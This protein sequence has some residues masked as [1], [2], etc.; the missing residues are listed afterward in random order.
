MID[1]SVYPDLDLP[2]EQLTDAESRADYVHRICAA[3]DYGIPPTPATFDLFS[4]WKDVFDAFP[5]M[6]STGYHAFRA[7]F[8]WPPVAIDATLVVGKPR[9]EQLDRAEGRPADD[10]E[11]MV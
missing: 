1:H 3:W 9:W 6:T 4:Q 2:P 10:C 5:I 7:W 11:S 8:G